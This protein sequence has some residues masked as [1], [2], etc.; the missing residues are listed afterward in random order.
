M[1]ACESSPGFSASEMAATGSR[2][3]RSGASGLRVQARSRS[4]RRQQHQRRRPDC[5][6]VPHHPVRMQRR[7]ERHDCGG[8]QPP[9][10]PGIQPGAFTR[11]EPPAKPSVSTARPTSVSRRSNCTIGAARPGPG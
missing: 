9:R 6:P 7:L 8:R 2:S 4:D 1:R 3:N 5:P 11:R 10:H